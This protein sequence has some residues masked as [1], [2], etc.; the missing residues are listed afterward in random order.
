MKVVM[1]EQVCA[2]MAE[3]LDAVDVS[4]ASIETKLIMLTAS[5]VGIALQ[6]QIE[7]DKKLDQILVKVNN[8]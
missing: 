5:A 3:T 1:T 6:N 8:N 4:T 7:L 2:M